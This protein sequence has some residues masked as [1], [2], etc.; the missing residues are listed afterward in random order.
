[1]KWNLLSH[2]LPNPWPSFRKLC[3]LQPYHQ[4]CY[5]IRRAWRVV[6]APSEWMNE[7][8]TKADWIALLTWSLKWGEFSRTPGTRFQK[9]EGDEDI[10]SSSTT[11]M[12]QRASRIGEN[13]CLLYFKKGSSIQSLQRT[14]KLNTQKLAN[15]LT[16]WTDSDQ[17]EH[18]RWISILK[19]LST[20]NQQKCK[21]KY[22]EIKNTSQ[23]NYQEIW[24]QILAN[25][26]TKRDPDSMIE[27]K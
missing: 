8:W 25:I 3:E 12:K 20:M 10:T 22:F 2:T 23:N 14:F 13:P 26:C 18:K 11:T 16:K 4:H 6:E 21:L 1:M 15:E 27:R 7:E 5:G 19:L 9:N 17:K 24:E